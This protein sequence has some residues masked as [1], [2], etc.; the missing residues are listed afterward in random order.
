M[1]IKELKAF[2]LDK[3]VKEE[4]ENTLTLLKNAGIESP[5]V[6]G[7]YCYNLD[8]IDDIDIAV[9]W[10]DFE[11]YC[12]KNNKLLY[13]EEKIIVCHQNFFSDLGFKTNENKNSEY[14]DSCTVFDTYLKE[15]DLL[16]LQII[17]FQCGWFKKAITAHN[18]IKGIR[19][20]QTSGKIDSCK[21]LCGLLEIK[22]IRKAIFAVIELG[23]DDFENETMS[24]LAEND[25]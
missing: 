9:S 15:T 6:Y 21:K 18:I 7:S 8:E 13:N 2:G 25:L 19:E 17:V 5:I 24:E 20:K 3:K 14:L 16:P 22:E 1:N 11:K 23:I 10:E 4:I 12:A